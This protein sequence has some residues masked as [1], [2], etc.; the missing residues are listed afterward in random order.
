M[1]DRTHLDG[2][3]HGVAKL[4][5]IEQIL[6]RTHGLVAAHIGVD[7]DD[8]AILFAETH[9]LSR[10]FERHF[11]RLLAKDTAKVFALDGFLHDLKLL[12]RRVCDVENLKRIVLQHFPPGSVYFRDPMSLCASLGVFRCAGCDSNRVKAGVSVGNQVAVSHDKS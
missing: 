5:C 7:G 3:E 2:G 8:L 11:D 10:V 1:R 12:I 4:F 6:Q 9:D